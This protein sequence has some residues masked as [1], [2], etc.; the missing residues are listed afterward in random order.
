MPNP[1][2][3]FS[4]LEHAASAIE[5]QIARYLGG[6]MD[7]EEEQ[8]FHALMAEDPALSDEVRQIQRQTNAHLTPELVAAE[9][10][11]FL[12]DLF[13]FRTKTTETSL[14]N[15]VWLGRRA[16]VKRRRT[17]TD[18]A[19]RAAPSQ[20]YFAAES[21]ACAQEVP[22]SFD[23]LLNVWRRACTEGGIAPIQV[24]ETMIDHTHGWWF[25]FC[26]ELAKGTA[27]L[28]NA[29]TVQ[30]WIDGVRTQLFDQPGLWGREWPARLSW[31]LQQAF[32]KA[33]GQ[34]LVESLAGDADGHGLPERLR[35]QFIQSLTP[36]T[37]ALVQSMGE[38]SLPVVLILGNSGKPGRLRI[39]IMPKG[40]GLLVPTLGMAMVPQTVEVQRVCTDVVE[41]LRR[42][43]LWSDELDFMWELTVEECSPGLVCGTS[44][45]LP[46]AFGCAW[47]A[48]RMMPEAQ[49]SPLSD[50]LQNIHSPERVCCTGSFWNGDRTSGIIPKIENSLLQDHVR[51][52][53]IDSST[54][55]AVS[56]R[57]GSSRTLHAQNTYL[58][59]RPDEVIRR[60]PSARN[61]LPVVVCS[62]LAELVADVAVE[63]DMPNVCWNWQADEDV[64]RPELITRRPWVD[65]AVKALWKEHPILILTGAAGTGKTSC[66]AKLMYD[67]GELSTTSGPAVGHIIQ[68]DSRRRKDDPELWLGSLTA[69]LRRKFRLATPRSFLGLTKDGS[70]DLGHHAFPPP[71]KSG[72]LRDRDRITEAAEKLVGVLVQLMNMR[73]CE[74]VTLYVDGLEKAYGRNRRFASDAGSMPEFIKALKESGLIP[75]QPANNVSHPTNLQR[76]A[77]SGAFVRMLLT[78]RRELDE[79]ALVPALSTPCHFVNLCGVSRLPQVISLDPVG[80]N[81]AKVNQD[82]RHFL[83]DSRVN[84]TE[85]K[86]ILEH[87]SENFFIASRVMK[88]P[89]AYNDGKQFHDVTGFLEQEF[90]IAVSRFVRGPADDIYL[91]ASVDLLDA[92]GMVAVARSPISCDLLSSLFGR[93][94]ADQIRNAITGGAPDFFKGDR[95]GIDGMEPLRFLHP[96]MREFIIA[97]GRNKEI[98]SRPQ[99]YRVIRR[100]K[101][102]HQEDGDPYIAWHARYAK[103]CGR[104]AE[105]DDDI[106]PR[107]YALRHLLSHLRQCQNW[108]CFAQMAANLEFLK[109]K[110][111][112][113]N[114]GVY[115]LVKSIHKAFREEPLLP[116]TVAERPVIQEIANI[117]RPHESLIGKD[118]SMAFQQLHNDLSETAAG[119][120]LRARLRRIL[121]AEVGTTKPLWMSAPYCKNHSEITPRLQVHHREVIRAATF[122][123][124]PSPQ[125]GPLIVTAGRGGMLHV[126]QVSGANP[127]ILIDPDLGIVIVETDDHSWAKRSKAS[128][129]LSLAQNW[130][131][132]PV[133]DMC[134]VNSG[135]TLV[136]LYNGGVSSIEVADCLC[137]IKSV[138]DGEPALR[139]KVRRLASFASEPQSI[140]SAGN[141]GSL[142]V[143]GTSDW[144]CRICDASSMRAVL[145]TL[146]MHILEVQKNHGASSH[147]QHNESKNAVE[148]RPCRRPALDPYGCV[149]MSRDETLVA[150]G[151]PDQWIRVWQIDHAQW[152]SNREL[153]S[154]AS[155]KTSAVSAKSPYRLIAELP[156]PTDRR[157][158]SLSFSPDGETLVAGGGFARGVLELWSIQSG[159]CKIL[160]AHRDC[161]QTSTCFAIPDNDGQRTVYLATAGHDR[162][163]SLWSLRHL[164]EAPV[165]SS[166]RALT[167]WIN[168]SP[169]KCHIAWAAPIAP[170]TSRS[171]Q[172]VIYRL[173][174]SANDELL[175]SAGAD[176]TAKVFDI[177]ALLS[178]A[179]PP[180]DPAG[181]E[182]YMNTAAFDP[183]GDYFVTGGA[184]SKF[185]LRPVKASGVSPESVTLNGGEIRA[186]RISPSGHQLAVGSD[187]EA[188]VCELRDHQV[189]ASIRLAVPDRTNVVVFPK[190]SRPDILLATGS[191]NGIVRIHLKAGAA[192]RQNLTHN[193]AVR[194]I[195]FSDDGIWIASGGDDSQLIVWQLSD[196]NKPVLLKDLRDGDGLQRIKSVAFHPKSDLLASGGSRNITLWRQLGEQWQAV[197]TLRGH[198]DEVW[199]MVFSQ[200][201]RYLASGSKDRTVRIWDL[202]SPPEARRSA[203]LPR[204]NSVLALW[205]SPDSKRLHVADAGPAAQLPDCSV[206]EIH[207][208]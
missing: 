67:E 29:A 178:S 56:S 146:E 45:G 141:G 20:R 75:D 153:E 13:P 92:L 173:C 72:L 12:D 156:P 206:V 184:D 53:V 106:E 43:H 195:D 16:A 143:V 27:P 61:N 108:P 51:L 69:Q 102:R 167:A 28:P 193:G 109:A 119:N 177:R 50:S 30:G 176:C 23:Q 136:Y 147:G 181:H 89:A 73:V 190:P 142:F 165:R 41:E 48:V 111:S 179:L 180:I 11:R 189:V 22:T 70:D 46:L 127:P 134:F 105:F 155:R 3:I 49:I 122:C 91:D 25:G 170:I 101:E 38:I 65:K 162:T 191:H 107:G 137:A 34:A 85:F 160:P 99:L 58:I 150:M 204:T 203:C 151:C 60:D 186:V 208:L 36:G 54:A 126:S 7:D 188:V 114:L 90:F 68:R 66:M 42:L 79:C 15:E 104:W 21:A 31:C 183:S 86:Q 128:A 9:R 196:P 19:Y 40:T 35:H 14:Q 187:H 87:S 161:I 5:D 44:L 26:A 139:I 1:S 83:D 175:A 88:N 64:K 140:S 103:A 115:D 130:R 17:P 96:M 71:E 4:A 33:G 157:I 8:D 93:S 159:D 32:A 39:A 169:K 145:P 132:K 202:Q 94:A 112:F 131:R 24:I 149:A 47:L 37:S 18:S 164:L 76:T 55:A 123:P 158:D 95:P 199:C 166:D 82:L 110:I 84:P 100:W 63:E 74:S 192:I 120:S 6:L 118:W 59:Q 10:T 116:P 194:A 154:S 77:S 174:V 152:Q 81:K 121:A 98:Q 57:F 171:H 78:S 129:K 80:G 207:G 113:S 182:N 133:L 135:K 117:L 198:L 2:K 125:C 168:D 205:F 172:D 148:L 200:C 138:E 197:S 201:G 144:V 97:M 52:M 124:A 185:S 163:F 62:S